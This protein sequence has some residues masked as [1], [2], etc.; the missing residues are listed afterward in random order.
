MS[1]Q[2]A[3]IIGLVWPEPTSSAAGS[4]M[5]QLIRFL[6]SGYEVS[7]ACAAA[8]GPHSFDLAALGV[9]THEIRLNDDHFNV[10]IKNIRPAIVMFDRFAM[11]EQ[12]G[13][14]VQQ[15]CPDSLKILD[16]EDLHT[17]RNARQLAVKSGGRV[18]DAEQFT[19]LAKRELAAILRCDLSLIISA[20]EMDILRDTYR[21]DASL[22]HHLP[23]LEEQIT[24]TAAAQWRDFEDREGFVFIGNL[25]H[26][27]NWD[28]VQYLKKVVWPVLRK[29]LPDVTLNIY[30]AYASQKVMQLHQEKDRFLVHGRA[31]DALTAISSHRVLIAPI[32]FGAGLKGKFIDAMKSGTPSVTTTIGAEGMAGNMEWPGAIADQPEQFVSSATALYLDELQWTEARRNGLKIIN[33]RY[34]RSTFESAL[35]L[36]L[37]HLQA[38][39]GKHRQH[40]FVGQ[41]LQHHSLNSLKYMSLWIS[42]KNKKLDHQQNQRAKQDSIAEDQN[43]G[44]N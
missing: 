8:K 13:W 34:G 24:A 11:E 12:Y 39:L 42:E 15:E 18:S 26:E 21:I 20:A 44:P 28:T 27:P 2:T 5:L 23:F 25:L 1:A 19:D 31:A 40:N 33:E 38:T 43:E 22:L 10:L 29:R 35:H 3:L 7:F 32:R 4:R 17:L 41:I 30:G 37:R 9:T 6:Q 36:K 16:T 14:R